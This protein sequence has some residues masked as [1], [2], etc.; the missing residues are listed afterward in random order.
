MVGEPGCD[1]SVRSGRWRLAAILAVAGLACCP[2][3]SRA[4]DEA[5]TLITELL[6]DPDKD[7]RAV[8]LEQVRT[9]A[10]GEAA[11][12]KFA[13]LLPTLPPETQVGLLSA[14]AARGDAAAAPE[15]RQL[16]SDGNEELVR[17]AAIEA[18]G[19]LG[20]EMDV[21]VLVDR[22]A[23]GGD[24][25]KAAR[26]SLIRLPG[27]KASQ[28]IIHQMQQAPAPQRVA[29]IEILT[30]RRAGEDQLLTAALDDDPQVRRAAMEALGRL[31]TPEHIAKMAQAVLKAAPGSER[32][33]AERA[34]ALVCHRISDTAHQAAPLLDAMNQFDPEQRLELMPALGRV[35]GPAA[36]AAAEKAFS[37]RDA[38]KH[39][40]GLAALCNW[41]DGVVV[42]RLLEIARI[43]NHPEHRTLARRA[44]I[45]IAPLE[46]ARSDA[47]RLDLIKT[48]AVMCSDDRERNQLLDRAKAV[49]TVETLRFVSPYLNQPALSQQACTTVV[50]LAHHSRLR[51]LHKEEF[52]RALDKVI[53]TSQDA[54]VIDRAQRYQ[55]GQTWVRPK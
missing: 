20:N 25:Q 16:L 31:A 46:D 7:I 6:R 11:T 54:T 52:H 40:A 39:A 22:L 43:D 49:R 42:G 12:R 26:Q 51:E 9:E 3:F 36:L 14:L 29:L 48:L 1:A 4:Q 47:L 34:I 10:K 24:A 19:H 27:Q 37:D 23:G 2:A 28:A 33:A 44:L 38:S 53:A 50:E 41:P 5:L 13:E 21:A 30:E 55:R 17:I 15:V 18:I 8:A 35:G 45:R 32:I